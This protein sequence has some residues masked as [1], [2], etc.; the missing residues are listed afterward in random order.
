MENKGMTNSQI[1]TL[2]KVLHMAEVFNY[3]RKNGLATKYEIKQYEVKEYDCFVSV[4]LEVGM[5]DDKGTWASIF[6]RDRVHLFI[7]KRGGISYPVCGRKVSRVRLGSCES[8]LT[9]NLAQK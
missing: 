6:C 7:G 3:D 4:A 1:K 2:V 5:K 8:L 9:V